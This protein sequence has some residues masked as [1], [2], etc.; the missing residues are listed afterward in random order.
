MSPC[1]RGCY[2]VLLTKIEISRNSCEFDTFSAAA[3]AI[4]LSAIFSRLA[5]AQT[6]P[7][8][9]CSGNCARAR[10]EKMLASVAWTRA[11]VRPK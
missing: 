10:R 11:L 2:P 8:T 7:R 9:S 3:G 5:R 4:T 6:I 1:K